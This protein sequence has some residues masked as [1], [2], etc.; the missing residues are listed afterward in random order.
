MLISG[1]GEASGVAIASELL[2]R[3]AQLDDEDRLTFFRF[4][5][6]ELRPDADRVAAA[7]QAYLDDPGDVTLAR[8][9]KALDSPRLEFFRRLNL[10]PGATARDRRHA[11]RPACGST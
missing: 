1:R 7:A 2:D 3:Y 4:L 9:Q 5:A 6:T 8:L 11:L 10:A